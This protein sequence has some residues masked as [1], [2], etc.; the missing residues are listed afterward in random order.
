VMTLT[1]APPQKMNKGSSARYTFVF[2]EDF[3]KK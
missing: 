1:R 2:S 3:G